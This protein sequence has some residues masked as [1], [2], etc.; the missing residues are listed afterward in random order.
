[1][2]ATVESQEQKNAVVDFG[3]G[4][5]S[6]IMK[7]TYTDLQNLFGYSPKVAEK[8]AR[9]LGSDLGAVHRTLDF[10]V[11]F[12]KPNKDMMRALTLKAKSAKLTLPPCIQ[13]RVAIDF[14]SDAGGSYISYGNTKWSFIPLLQEWIQ[15][16]TK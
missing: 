11:T 12:G 10:K 2:P 13:I 5:F 4:H 1:M 8:L 9:Q 14:I 3:N 7:N 6:N 15:E 16:F